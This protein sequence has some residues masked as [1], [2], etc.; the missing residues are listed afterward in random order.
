M[1]A[2]LLLTETYHCGHATN[3]FSQGARWNILRLSSVRGRKCLARMVFLIFF[4]KTSATSAENLS[5]IFNPFRFTLRKITH[6]N[7]LFSKQKKDVTYLCPS[8]MINIVTVEAKPKKTT[9][10]R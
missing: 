1:M 3:T 2:S 5:G 9:F 8:S 4:F 6:K 7:L 10:T